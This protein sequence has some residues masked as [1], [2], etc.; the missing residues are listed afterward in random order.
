MLRRLVEER[1]AGITFSEE[2]RERVADVLTELIE[3]LASREVE[4]VEEEEGAGGPDV[5]DDR[6]ASPCADR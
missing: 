1:L 4:Q 3:T 5:S 2:S 6:P